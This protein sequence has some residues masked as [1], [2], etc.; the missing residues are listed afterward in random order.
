[1]G[2][3]YNGQDLD[4]DDEK[5]LLEAVFD[6]EIVPIM[7]AADN[8]ALTD[9]HWLVIRF[10]RDQYRDKGHTPNFR[11]LVK[12]LEDEQSGTDWKKTLYTLFPNQP[13]RQAVRVAGLPKPFGKGG[14]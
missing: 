9:D 11:N 7:A 1:M 3:H 5:F 2:I 8:I 6:D 13:A 12:E 4:V 14:Y 10:L